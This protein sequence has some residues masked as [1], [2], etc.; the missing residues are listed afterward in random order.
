MKGLFYLILISVIYLVAVNCAQVGSITGGEKDITPPEIV[1]SRPPNYSKNFNYNKIEIELNE[2]IRFDNLK[3][4]LVISPLL[5]ESPEIFIRGK[6]IMIELGKQELKKNT[7]YTFSFYD[8]I[9]DNNEGN[10]I[11]DYEFVF[12]TGNRLDSL[13]INGIVLNAFDLLPEEE[14]VEV[15]LYD[16]LHDTIP[17]TTPPLYIGKPDEEGNFRINNIKADTFRIF[18]LKDANRNHYFDQAGEKFA[19]LDSN[20]VVD[21][22]PQFLEDTA[23]KDT[24][25][26]DSGLVE[27]KVTRPGIKLFLFEEDHSIQYL[28]NSKRETREHIQFIFNKPLINRDLKINALNFD[29]EDKWFIRENF[30]VGDTVNVW[31]TDTTASNSD[32]LTFELTY[33]KIDSTD[34]IIS[35]NDTVLMRFIP[36][37]GKGEKVDA[38]GEAKKQL[39][40][41]P[42]V[43]DNSILELNRNVDVVSK[44]P[45]QILDTSK[46]MMYLL[47][48]TIKKDIEYKIKQDSL[49]IRKFSFYTDWKGDTKYQLYFEPGAFTSIYGNRSDTLQLNF[50]TRR[51]E[52]YGKI[53][54]TLNYDSENIIIQLIDNN[55][56]VIKENNDWSDKTHEFSY[57]KAGNY[58]LKAIYDRNN[59]G[60][61]DTGEYEKKIQPEKVKFYDKELKVRSNWDLEI[62]W[63]PENN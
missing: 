44:T 11:E 39:V 9:V 60:K 35:F 32:L 19:F 18:A 13:S 37:S 15:L 7:T 6:K 36:P 55:D 17:R 8:A 14:E 40:L 49:Q 58:S 54:L 59:N 3:Q 57:L 26:S 41:T 47:D 53:I 45:V 16:K 31:I 38:G 2:Y 30:V 5:E 52:F 63:D 1:E 33:L 27:E 22:S 25:L 50:T 34:N 23:I 28:K 56:K 12:T 10:P 51:K 43:R 20:I 21:V 62:S 61:W 42:A 29:S 48:D 46:V 4:K 24:L